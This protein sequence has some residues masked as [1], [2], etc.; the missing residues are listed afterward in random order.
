[1]DNGTTQ[2]QTHTDTT[3]IGHMDIVAFTTAYTVP[4]RW[5]VPLIHNVRK[6]LSDF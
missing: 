2:L 1:M 5:L 6:G 3:G 4:S